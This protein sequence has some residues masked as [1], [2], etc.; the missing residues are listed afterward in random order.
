MVL[1][2]HVEI[3]LRPEA[4]RPLLGNSVCGRMLGH[5]EASGGVVPFS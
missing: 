2:T 4:L 3:W 1:V 5:L